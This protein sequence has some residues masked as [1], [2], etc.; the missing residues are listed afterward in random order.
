MLL[1][2]GQVGWLGR[3]GR[4]GEALRI[5]GIYQGSGGQLSS[6]PATKSAVVR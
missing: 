1:E 2:E 5:G 6:A 4:A 3:A